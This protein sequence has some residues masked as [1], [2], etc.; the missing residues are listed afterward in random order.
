M[1]AVTLFDRGV[2]HGDHAGVPVGDVELPAA[3]GDHD[4]ARGRAPTG[5]VAPRDGIGTLAATAGGVSGGAAGDSALGGAAAEVLGAA[6]GEG[7]ALVSVARRSSR[8][9]PAAPAR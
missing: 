7:P 6:V 2:H 5:M 4:E 1:V 3:G 9:R 8:C